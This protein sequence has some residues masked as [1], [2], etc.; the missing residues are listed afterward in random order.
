MP[1]VAVPKKDGKVRICGDYK[2]T[3]NQAIDVDQ[4]PLPRPADLF[5][6]LAK[7]KRFSKLDL[8]QTYQQMKLDEK[9]AQFLTINTHMGM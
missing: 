5:A 3:I 1:N 2:V 6:T 8:S 7:G 9:S 4:Y